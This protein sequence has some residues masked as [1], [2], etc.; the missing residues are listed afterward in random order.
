M[1]HG[2]PVSGSA[3][4]PL[5][6]ESRSNDR[7]GGVR[8]SACGA[9]SGS[10]RLVGFGGGA[11]NSVTFRDVTAAEAGNYRLQFDHTAGSATS[12]SVRVNGAA[13]IDVAVPAGNPDVPGSTAVSV[14]LV[15]GANTVQVFSRG[16][17][18]RASTGSPSDRCRRRRTCPRRR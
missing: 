3:Q 18:D 2:A 5:E 16:P 8:P 10:S 4:V 12:L 1:A 14:P 13:A 7:D 17:G 11:R 15:A 9:C 6:A